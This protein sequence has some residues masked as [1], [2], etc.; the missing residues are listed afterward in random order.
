MG[1]MTHPLMQIKRLYFLDTEQV[2]IPQMH[3]KRLTSAFTV[4]LQTWQVVGIDLLCF[5]F[6][7]DVLSL[8]GP[9]LDLMSPDSISLNVTEELLY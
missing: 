3:N 9:R 4:L 5:R 7:F 2:S 8:S 6:L 1:I